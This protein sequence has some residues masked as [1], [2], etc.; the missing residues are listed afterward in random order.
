MNRNW[1]NEFLEGE[2]ADKMW[3]KFCSIMNE[4]IGKFIPL[5]KPWKKNNKW[6]HPVNNEQRKMIRKKHRLYARWREKLTPEA[7]RAYKKQRNL[8]RK[9]SQNLEKK[10]QCE[11]ARQCKTNPK[12]FW[13]YVKSKREGQERMPDLKVIDQYGNEIRVT[14]DSEKAEVFAQHFATVFTKES[15]D[16]FTQI[17]AANIRVPMTAISLSSDLIRAKL[18]NL[19]TDK[20]PGPDLLHP[21]IIYE[22]RDEIAEPLSKLFITTLEKRA[23]PQEWK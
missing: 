4:G 21:R 9:E 13:K 15:N 16:T 17:P 19:K 11:V 10:Q 5:T 12:K 18:K 20:S 3:L 6:K 8:V 14:K 1:K 2:D 23:L 7:E 22:V